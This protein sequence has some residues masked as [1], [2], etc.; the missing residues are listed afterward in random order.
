MDRRD[1]YWS[2]MLNIQGWA[3]GPLAENAYLL[4]CAETGQAVFIDP[5]DDAPRL[6]QAIVD[7]KAQ[8][9]AI[10][11]THAHL[12][13]VA[14]LTELREATGAPVYLHPADDELLQHAPLYWAAFGRELAP[15]A[16][17]DHALAHGQRITFGTCEL[18]VLHTP[19][20]TP[21]SVCFHEPAQH[22][23]IAGDTLFFRS[24]GRTDLPGGDSQALIRSIRH[25]LWPLPD[26]TV[27]L[28]GHGERTTI[29]AERQENPFVGAI[30]GA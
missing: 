21:G 24:V 20:H 27:V 23:L 12:D 10:L 26:T 28:P 22:T 9:Q 19:G 13:H 6:L 4:A 30:S 14:A 18:V 1:D 17:A 3:V 16:P 7:T 11:L 25:E 29:G 5:G 15:I 8:V 2:P